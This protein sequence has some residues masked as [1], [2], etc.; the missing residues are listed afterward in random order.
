MM[1]SLALILGLITGILPGHPP[2]STFILKNELAAARR[3]EP[4]VIS[5]SDFE[6]R[7][8]PGQPNDVPVLK[9]NGQ[10]IP[11]QADDLN[12]DGKWD[13]LAFVVNMEARSSLTI[14]AIWQS[15]EKAP[16]FEKRTQA[17]LAGQNQDGSFTEVRKAEAPVGLDGF[18]SRYQ[19]EGVGW[20]NDKIAF[21]VYFDCRNTKDLFGKLI[22]DLILSKAGS[23][24]WGSYHELAPWGMDILHCGSS[25]GAGGLALAEG[26]S[27]FRLGST[28]VYQYAEITEGPVRT[29]FEL[30]YKG[31][32][33][34]G[35]QYEAVERITLWIGKYWFQSDVTVRDFQGEKQLATGIVTTKLNMKPI[36]FQAN[37]DFTV[38][39][40]HG[41]QSLN[42]DFLAMAVMAPSGE[43]G[44]IGRTTDTD[45]FKLGYR[46]VPDKSFSQVI[47]ETFYL[48][49]KIQAGTPAVHYFFALW[50]LEDPTWNEAEPVRE[51][52]RLEADKIS[53]PVT[54]EY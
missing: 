35:H 37:T 54:I 6:N 8:G 21:R 48:T 32:E 45:Y 13:E 44:K 30:R 49:Q 17:Y 40:T 19:S 10:L 7:V 15:K 33:V 16:V 12:G 20:E 38:I 5:R 26:D 31:W 11:A 34:L 53:H 36:Q 3:N 29:I 4:V 51:Y 42:N 46:T 41:K 9:S 28:P 23:A 1:F 2:E 25:L 14:E 27:L 18:P 22:P 47:S 39:F 50:G 52:I 24:E 43:V